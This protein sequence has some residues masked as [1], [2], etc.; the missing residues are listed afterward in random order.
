[1]NLRVALSWTQIANDSRIYVLIIEKIIFI[2]VA[3]MYKGTGSSEGKFM[4]GA[5]FVKVLSMSLWYILT[6]CDIKDIRMELLC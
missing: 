1:M 3:Y 4:S 6:L 2:V 5:I